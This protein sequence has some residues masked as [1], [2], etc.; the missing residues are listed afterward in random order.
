LAQ[1]RQPS[2]SSNMS[3]K[4]GGS[5]GSGGGGGGGGSWGGGS[6]W[7]KE[8]SWQAEKKPS[9]EQ[10]GSSWGS[11]GSSGKGSDKGSSKGGDSWGSSGGSSWGSSKGDSKGSSKGDS[12]G[13]SKGSGKSDDSW[14]SKGSSKG[15]SKSDNSWE[16]PKPAWEKPSW[17]KPSWGSN[18][19]SKGSKG[20]SKGAKG[21]SKGKDGKS[22]KGTDSK[23]DWQSGSKGKDGKDGKGGKDGKATTLPQQAPKQAA[24][25]V[26]GA[27]KAEPAPKAAEKGGKADKAGKGAPKAEIKP[28]TPAKRPLETAEKGGLAKKVATEAPK[29]APKAKVEPKKPEPKAEPKKAEP[30]KAPEPKPKPEPPKP[31]PQTDID[32]AVKSAG[33]KIKAAEEALSACQDAE[34]PY[35]RGI[36]VLPKEEGDTVLA[37]CDAAIK[38]AEPSMKPTMGF[39]KSKMMEYR[40]FQADSTKKAVEDLTALEKKLDKV[41]TKFNAFTKDT[42][43]RKA[44]AVISE[45]TDSVVVA[46]KKVKEVVEATKDFG[47]AEKVKE[48]SV[49]D[50]K[51]GSASAAELETAAAAACN[52]ARKVVS[53]VQQ[54]SKSR[55][56]QIKTAIGKLQSRLGTAQGELTK[57][58]KLIADSTELIINKE[59]D[60][61]KIMEEVNPKATAAEEAVK[62]VEEAAEPM[63]GLK[64]ADLE[65]FATPVS[66]REK[67]ESLLASGTKIVDEA[68]ACVKENQAKL[69]KV[70]KGPLLETKKELGKILV[71]VEGLTR[72]AAAAVKMVTLQCQTLSEIRF[73]AAC[74]ALRAEVQKKGTTADE[75]FKKI[76]KGNYVKPEAVIKLLDSVEG[77]G[78]PEE[79]KK[80]LCKFLGAGDI[81]KRAF[82]RMVKQFL[83]V[84]KGTAITNEFA[85]NTGKTLRKAEI[86]EVFEVLEGPK[87]DEELGLQRVRA[88]SLLDGLEGWVA[89]KGNK[90]TPFLEEVEK[91][92][93][94]ITKD[95]AL[96]KDFESG[97]VI[98]TL[99]AEEIFEV[100]EGP[101]T[102]K[103][104]NAMRA[105]GK[106]LPEGK[107]GWFTVKDTLGIVYA[108]ASTK[109]YVCKAAVA[110]TDAIDIKTCKVV[111]RL[112]EGELLLMT[113]G[114][115]D[116]EGITRINVKAVKD[117]ES[118]WITTTGNA[119]TVYAEPSPAKL[120]VVSKDTDLEEKFSGDINKTVDT[121]KAGSFI[122]VV[123]GPR[124]EKS[125]PVTKFKGVLLSDEKTGWIAQKSN[126]MRVWKPTYKCL[127]ATVIT[128]GEKA[129]S[130]DVRSLEF[131]EMVEFLEGPMAGEEKE[132]KMKGRAMKDGAIGYITIVDAKGMQMLKSTDK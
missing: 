58:K 27:P 62:A 97:D 106:L 81:T 2:Y 60:P 48:M 93:Y 85:V 78:F 50:L 76:G 131:G 122:E 4:G 53:K 13:S 33:E 119:G 77:L 42:A 8:D 18:N 47:D 105:K 25:G 73:K 38:K 127:K 68:K 22:A 24:K 128:K 132:M 30:K 108:E 66:V 72:K 39:I 110:I 107:T 57:Q 102:L 123:E 65:A 71:K 91:P 111:R 87:T 82:D 31:P 69:I 92:Y 28:F 115:E 35:L 95:V 120:Y 17:E 63:K 9:W 116:V 23:P 90:G 46:E 94:L 104:E 44:A 54:D 55:G 61:E 26:K 20:D 52:E 1:G 34:M 32:A 11:K 45:V 43:D 12:K 109:F 41:I 125:A 10:S 89:V 112:A 100:V 96:E 5:W 124:E 117:G 101:K 74:D 14:G 19:D 56:P 121:I 83:V 79:H 126:N 36:E 6:S 21:D 118:G 70:S 15:T 80:L 130:G 84:V 59:C 51:T 86:N 16:K 99:K 88:K 49:D 3:W 37:E 98:R 64:D 29:A 129:D 103:V 7:K 75:M 114:P 113:E 67:A 40:K